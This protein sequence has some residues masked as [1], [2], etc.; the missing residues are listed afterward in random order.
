[1]PDTSPIM[2]PNVLELIGTRSKRSPLT[3]L[4]A[5]CENEILKFYANRILAS[6]TVENKQ[7]IENVMVKKITKNGIGSRFRISSIL[8]ERDGHTGSIAVEPSSA[9]RASDAAG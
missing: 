7:S 5:I 8:P 2:T 1:M 4:L 6:N 3:I 9:N